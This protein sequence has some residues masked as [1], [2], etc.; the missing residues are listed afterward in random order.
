MDVKKLIAELRRELEGVNQ[1]INALDR[2]KPSPSEKK[3]QAAKM[4]GRSPSGQTGSQR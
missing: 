3:G 2:L 4:A 1:A